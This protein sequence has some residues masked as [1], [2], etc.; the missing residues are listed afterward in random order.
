MGFFKNQQIALIEEGYT[1]DQANRVLARL[2]R[3]TD[4]RAE[5]VRTF[6][7]AGNRTVRFTIN[8]HR[9]ERR[10]LAIWL[11]GGHEWARTSDGRT[12]RLDVVTDAK[13]LDR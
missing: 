13:V 3:P 1:L 4:R 10:V 7:T 5:I 6:A 9:R 11:T 2:A 8:G 12:I